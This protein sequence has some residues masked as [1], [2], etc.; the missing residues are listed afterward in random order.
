MSRRVVFLGTPAWAVPTLDALVESDWDVTGVVTNPDRP[1]GRG[2]KLVAPPVKERA[3]ELGLDVFQPSSAKGPE[4]AMWMMSQ[5]PRAAI[6]VAYGKILPG[7]LLEVPPLG[8]LNVHFSLLPAYRGAAPVQRA[9]MDGVP[10]TGVSIMRLTEGMDEGPVL[11]ARRLPLDPSRTAGEIGEELSEIGASALVG[12][13]DD[14]AAGVITPKDQDHA[15]ATYASKITNEEAS[16]DWRGS[17]EEIRRHVHGL[18][19]FPGA[20][21][22]I[23]GKRFKVFRVAPV[24]VAGPPA[25]GRLRI[26]GGELVA[27]TGEGSLV[28]EDGQL[29]GKRRMMGRDIALG[30]DLSADLQLGEGS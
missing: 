16:I 24:E 25:P 30:L 19:P 3:L 9:V 22:T 26:E 10:E 5:A 17:A 20:W 4:M 18:S 7:A 8:F 12:A 28:I 29:A 21:T 6:V 2:Y 11:A 13:L 15:A 14:Y 23:R 1:A 27:G